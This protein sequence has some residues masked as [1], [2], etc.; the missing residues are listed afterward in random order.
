MKQK[1]FNLWALV[2]YM[3]KKRII[4]FAINH[5]E[6]YC[7]I[8]PEAV[9]SVEHNSIAPVSMNVLALIILP[10]YTCVKIVSCKK[11]DMES[12]RMFQ[13]LKDAVTENA[14]LNTLFITRPLRSTVRL[15]RCMLELDVNIHLLKDAPIVYLQTSSRCIQGVYKSI[16][17]KFADILRQHHQGCSWLSSKSKVL[18]TSITKHNIAMMVENR[19][20]DVTNE[21]RSKSFDA[22]SES[23]KMR[24]EPFLNIY[25][26]LRIPRT[27]ELEGSSKVNNGSGLAQGATT[28]ETLALDHFIASAFSKETNIH[29]LLVDD[30]VEDLCRSV[31][32]RREGE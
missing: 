28:Q 24:R 19:F 26:R 1:I 18:T 11:S 14:T 7:V 17:V 10:F 21:N 16:A 23:C 20:D 3:S 25:M 9:G 31:L 12:L 4:I 13:L 32:P 29:L 2:Y 27:I 6:V 30:T 15:K 5:K 22:V 8:L